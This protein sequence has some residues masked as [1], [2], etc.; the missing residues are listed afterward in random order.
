MITTN[1]ILYILYPNPKPPA[2]APQ[3]PILLRVPRWAPEFPGPWPLDPANSTEL[4]AD[5]ALGFKLE[6]SGF[7]TIW[8][9]QNYPQK[10]QSLGIIWEDIGLGPRGF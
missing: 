6:G 5:H 8:V 4:Y 9:P 2:S 10:I 3:K 1:S 7:R